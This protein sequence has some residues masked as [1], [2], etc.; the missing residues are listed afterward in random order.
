MRNNIP[1]PAKI[2]VESGL[3]KYELVDYD[4][5]YDSEQWDRNTLVKGLELKNSDSV[6]GTVL[7][8]LIDNRTLKVEIFPDKVAEEVDMFSDSAK[9]YER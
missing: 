2:T 7:V 8:E 1:D 5:Y 9:I 3:I 6:Y 4:F